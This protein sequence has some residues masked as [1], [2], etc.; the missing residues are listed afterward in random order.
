MV[1]Q[2]GGEERHLRTHRRRLQGRSPQAD[3]E[4]ARGVE[5]GFRQGRII[6]LKKLHETH[7]HYKN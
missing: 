5:K 6:N 2:A 4:Q 1:F 7:N 3:G